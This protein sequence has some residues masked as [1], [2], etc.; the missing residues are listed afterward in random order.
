VG[1]GVGGGWGARLGVR[2][3]EMIQKNVGR[4]I[5]LIKRNDVNETIWWDLARSNCC[6]YLVLF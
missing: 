4:W 1:R 5:Q 2:D 3:G 6:V